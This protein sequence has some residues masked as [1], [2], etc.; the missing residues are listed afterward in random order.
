[1]Q[2]APAAAFV[3]GQMIRGIKST[4]SPCC[5][6]VV[7]I[8]NEIIESGRFDSAI[9]LRSPTPSSTCCANRA[10]A[11]L[12]GAAEP[13]GAG[14]VIISRRRSTSTIKK[15]GY[16]RL[17][18]STPVPAVPGAMKGLAPPSAANSASSSC[19]IGAHEPGIIAAEP[20]NPIVTQ[21]ATMPDIEKPEAPVRVAHGI[22]V[23]RRGRHAEEILYPPH[24]ASIPPIASSLSVLTDRATARSISVTIG[25]SSADAGMEATGVSPSSSAIREVAAHGARHARRA[26]V[27]RAGQRLHNS[28]GC[29]RF[30]RYSSSPRGH[31]HA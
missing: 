1:M 26:R 17:R 20:P 2:N 27:R 11:R 5:A 19:Y 22:V 10:A 12:Q 9:P 7:F 8:S 30:S 31:T 29:C 25:R 15:V 23:F 16:D 3:D 24:S 21:L 13:R 28:T 4:C 14:A 18:S 6:D